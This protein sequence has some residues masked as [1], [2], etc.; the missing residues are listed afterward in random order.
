MATNDA[1]FV[2]DPADRAQA[3]ESGA[4]ACNPEARLRKVAGL[5]GLSRY[6]DA[7]FL[8]AVRLGDGLG[9]ASGSSLSTC[10]DH[11]H[12]PVYPTALSTIA[13]CTNRCPATTE[14]AAGISTATLR[15]LNW[16]VLV[17]VR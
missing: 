3:E 10:S 14:L 11:D 17:G 4:T 9:I 5:D 2:M 15:C 1:T 6:H 7:R 12:R 8:S 13:D 16:R